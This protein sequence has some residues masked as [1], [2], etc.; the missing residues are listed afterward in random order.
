MAICS[1]VNPALSNFEMPVDFTP[2]VPPFAEPLLP[3]PPLLMLLQET[4]L[5]YRCFQRLIISEDLPLQNVRFHP[6]HPFRSE[7]I[8]THYNL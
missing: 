7:P 2:H 8:F 3:P 6:Y 4:D 1:D 5:P